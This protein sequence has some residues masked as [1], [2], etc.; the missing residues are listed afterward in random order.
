M[1]VQTQQYLTLLDYIDI[2]Q[3]SQVRY[4]S[5]IVHILHINQA[6]FS[7]TLEIFQAYPKFLLTNYIISV[8]QISFYNSY[9]FLTLRSSEFMQVLA[10][11]MPEPFGARQLKN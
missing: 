1:L 4:L 11:F 2:S 7:Q 3:V 5:Y 10:C 6:N 9:S 8:I